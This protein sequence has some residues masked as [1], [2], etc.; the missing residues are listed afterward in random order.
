MKLW[1]MAAILL[2]GISL[3]NVSCSSVEDNPSVQ[4]GPVKP[5]AGFFTSEIN[6][7]IDA[8]YPEVIANGYAELIIPSTMFDTGMLK[9]ADYHSMERTAMLNI[10]YV[11]FSLT[12]S[13]LSK[14]A[15]EKLKENEYYAKGELLVEAY[16]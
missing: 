9:Y 4:P 11:Y 13:S 10:W 14:E 6:T 7:L 5:E 1:M 3:A 8:N 16:Q 15:L 12:D 2:C